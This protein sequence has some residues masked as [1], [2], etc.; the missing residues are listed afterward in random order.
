MTRK[1]RTNVALALLAA[2]IVFNIIVL[3][4]G[5]ESPGLPIAAI[6]VLLGAVGVSMLA[7]RREP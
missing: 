4:R 1:Y 7:E 6:V 5:E 2:A 3:V